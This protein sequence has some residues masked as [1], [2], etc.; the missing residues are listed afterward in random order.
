MLF[1]PPKNKKNTKKYLVKI[2][3]TKVS[4]QKLRYGIYGLKCIE[5]GYIS[6]QQ[7]ECARRVFSRN[8]KKNFG[9]IWVCAKPN[10]PKTKKPNEIRMGKG[11]GMIKGW[12]IPV[13]TGYIIFELTGIS[14]PVA[15]T[16]LKIASK[17]LPVKTQIVIGLV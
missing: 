9:Q 5:S 11:K 15:V 14:Y 13:H 8:I 4:N 3:S 16:L 17:K 2:T 6:P 1:N 7:L 12:Y 10:F